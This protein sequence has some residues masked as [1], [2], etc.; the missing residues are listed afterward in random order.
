MAWCR[1]YLSA[2]RVLVYSQGWQSNASIFGNASKQALFA[3]PLGSGPLGGSI[4]GFAD[5]ILWYLKRGQ[6]MAEFRSNDIFLLCGG[7]Y[8]YSSHAPLMSRAMVSLCLQSF[9]AISTGKPVVPFPQSFGPLKPGIDEGVVTNLCRKMRVLT[10]RDRASMDWLDERGFAEKSVLIPDIV[11]AMPLLMPKYYP[12]HTFDQR[13]GLGIAAADYSFAR[14]CEPGE[15]EGYIQ[16]L[17]DAATDF[18]RRFGGVI[19]LFIQV[20]LPGSDDDRRIVDI[21][22]GRVRAAGVPVEIIKPDNGL[23]D[24]LVAISKCKVF[25]G[26]RMH[27]CIFSLTTATPTIGLAYQPKFQGLFNHMDLDDWV[28]DIGTVDPSW[29]RERL[30]S[31]AEG[32]RLLSEVILKKVASL[33]SDILAAMDTVARKAGALPLPTMQSRD[34]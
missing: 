31:A 4:R 23:G 33:S 6:R 18:H 17:A 10:P 1:R 34:H 25:V 19:R 32:H 24:Y 28:T 20:S 2:N 3:P 21:L 12:A 29:L 7:G 16:T 22:A 27:A 26:S 30:I 15:T 13:A 9:A 8:L 14:R 11:L 5:I